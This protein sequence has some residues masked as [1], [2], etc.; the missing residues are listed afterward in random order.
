MN[1]YLVTRTDAGVSSFRCATLQ[2]A[3]EVAAFL[4]N[5]YRH[6][7]VEVHDT[8]TGERLFFYPGQ[9]R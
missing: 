1:R 3:K 2:R 7:L 5:T 9:P 4:A 8:E 6:A